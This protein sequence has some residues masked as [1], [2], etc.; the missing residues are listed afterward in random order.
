MMAKRVY[1]QV[2]PS[3]EEQIKSFSYL[4]DYARKDIA[5]AETAIVRSER[6]LA[7]A[8]DAGVA[9]YLNSVIA[10]CKK[11]IGFRISDVAMAEAKINSFTLKMGS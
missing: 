9:D 2:E 4:A 3:I 11:T 7:V 10:E 5:D 8:A 1:K 6:R